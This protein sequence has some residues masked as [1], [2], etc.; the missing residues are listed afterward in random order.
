MCDNCH[1]FINCMLTFVS[2]KC[3]KLTSFLLIH[4]L[5]LPDSQEFVYSV[6]L[7]ANLPQKLCQIE[8][9]E[10]SLLLEVMTF[11]FFMKR[12][13]IVNTLNNIEIS[14]FYDCISCPTFL[15]KFINTLFWFSCI[16][17]YFINLFWNKIC[18]FHIFFNS[19]NEIKI[20][21]KF[22]HK[23]YL[24]TWPWRWKFIFLLKNYIVIYKC[25]G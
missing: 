23:S 3:L 2:G 22:N 10:L 17:I 11:Y 5:Y 24:P 8:N 16:I 7:I 9:S 21:L 4:V 6:V 18:R 1:F 14:L 15:K 20:S 19:I 13:I 25:T 12:F